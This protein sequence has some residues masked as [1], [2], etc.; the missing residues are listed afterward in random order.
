MI[1]ILYLA[2]FLAPAMPNART[3]PGPD[4]SQ[5]LPELDG[6]DV[7]EAAMAED[8]ARLAP[9]LAAP[10]AADRA[11]LQDWLNRH[12]DMLEDSP[13]G[14]G[15]RL[16]APEVRRVRQALAR[17]DAAAH[18]GDRPNH[19]RLECGVWPV[20]VC[21][22][23]RKSGRAEAQCK[24]TS[25]QYTTTCFAPHDV[26]AS[27]RRYTQQLR[28]CTLRAW[29]AEPQGVVGQL[30]VDWSVQASTGAATIRSIDIRLHRD[31]AEADLSR[32]LARLG[33]RARFP[34]SR[35]A[36]G[37]VELVD[38]AFQHAIDVVVP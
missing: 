28:H 11:A 5:V 34:V 16:P 1:P 29:K 38:C 3:E 32:C 4:S 24:V 21:T 6:P 7:L 27:V 17:L 20:E 18:P 23:C 12:G 15:K 9:R 30:V 13:N 8:F 25:A 35:P 31:D 36:E 26:Q 22:G 19:T 14:G 2:L 33:E 37:S 10:T